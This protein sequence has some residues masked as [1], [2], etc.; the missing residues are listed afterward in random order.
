LLHGLLRQLDGV[1]R[2]LA[3]RKFSNGQLGGDALV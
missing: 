1:A 2:A 3:E